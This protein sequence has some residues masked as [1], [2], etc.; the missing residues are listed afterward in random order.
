MAK[1]NTQSQLEL[2]EGREREAILYTLYAR[3]GAFAKA[4]DEEVERRLSLVTPEDVARGGIE[5]MKRR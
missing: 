3:G 5:G 4:I 2:L 1:R